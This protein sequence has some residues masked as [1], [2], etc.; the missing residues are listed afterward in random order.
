MTQQEL[1]KV[2]RYDKSIGEF[3][4]AVGIGR[5]I[6][7]GIIAGCVNKDGY[8]QIRIAR[9]DYYAHRL[10]WLYIYGELPKDQID[11]INHDRRDNRLVNL[12]EVTQLENSRN[13]ALS[14]I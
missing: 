13:K 12:Q 6:K 14:K 7:K 3:R 5:R 2:L 1:K 10:A 8:I 11:H 9:K 4:W